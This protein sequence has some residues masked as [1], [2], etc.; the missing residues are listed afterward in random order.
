MF[1]ITHA[2]TG[3]GG[4]LDTD[5]GI[6]VCDGAFSITGQAPG[7]T[8]SIGII[9]DAANQGITYYNGI[10]LGNPAA[11]SNTVAGDI[12]TVC[13]DLTAQLLWFTN[14]RCRALNAGGWNNGTSAA[15]NPG[16]PVGGLSF[17]TMGSPAYILFGSDIET[18]APGATLNT[19]ASPF[20]QPIPSGY[21]AWEASNFYQPWLQRAPILSQ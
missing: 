5:Y 1:E 11:G 20:N 17:A 3:A 18:N 6:G 13:V 7:N 2:S 15:Q 19:G 16:T 4:V 9:L 14:P 8:T 21:Q 10:S 12:T